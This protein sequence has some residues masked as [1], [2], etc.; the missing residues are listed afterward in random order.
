MIDTSS[1]KIREKYAK[2][3]GE[4]KEW[5]S[6]IFGSVGVDHIDISTGRSYLDEF[7]KFFHMRKRRL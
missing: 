3:A 4:M 1:A 7:I 5:R 6:K 2:K